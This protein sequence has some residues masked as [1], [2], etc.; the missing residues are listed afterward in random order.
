MGKK[1]HFYNIRD[2]MKMYPEAKYYLAI[3]ERSNGKTYSSLDYALERFS[4]TQTEQFAYIRR[5][6]EDIK[7]AQMQKLFAAHNEDGRVSSL[8]PDWGEVIYERKT[9]YLAKYDEENEKI[10]RHE[11][12]IGYS[13]DLSGME[14]YKSISFPNVTT[15]IFDEFLS[16]KG[17]L[18]NEFELF[19]NMLS[20]I[21]R[22]RDNVKIIMLGNTVNKYCPYFGEMGLTHVKDQKQGTI[23]LYRYADSNLTVAVEYCEATKNKG[24]KASDVYFSF[25]NP[26][27]QMITGGSWEINIYPRIPFK[28]RPKDVV[29]QFF[30]D[31]DHELLHCELIVTP[32]QN[33]LILFI[34]PKT[35]DIKDPDNDI[36]YTDYPSE[37]WNYRMQMPSHSDRL[38]KTILQLVREN[39][40]Y[41]AS[42]ETGEIFR[43]YLLWCSTYSIKN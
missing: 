8:F 36:V 22:Q 35:S 38:T 42:N 25:D 6:G 41:Y 29:T 19:Q 28:Y 16:R 43:N 18:P 20:T 32:E 10:I 15:I 4:L 30:I 33:G 40:V 26:K 1:P 34:H 21:I 23:D 13:F 24:G 37:K 12:P 17:Y 14:H 5:F 2:M 9:F 27:L 11:R 39:R 3:G 7:P 31:F